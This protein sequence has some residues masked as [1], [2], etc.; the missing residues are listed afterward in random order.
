MPK[1]PEN[2][3]VA[4]LLQEG[5]VAAANALRNLADAPDK[6][7]R[8]AARRGLYLL[9]QKGIAPEERDAS[10]PAAPAP[11]TADTLRAYASACDGAGNRLLFF[12][13]PDPD[14]GRPTLMQT[15]INDEVGVKDFDAVRLARRDM[16]ERLGRFEEQLENGLALAEIEGDYARL[17][18]EE[19]WQITQY[20]GRAT[21]AGFPE[22]RAK[23]GPP[24]QNYEEP[25]VY[26]HLDAE[27]V[28]ADASIPHDPGD[29]FRL[30]W[31]EP[32]FFAVEEAFPYLDQLRELEQNQSQIVVPDSV[33]EE[34]REKHLSE[35]VKGLMDT[36]A[37]DRYVRRLEESAD[38]LRR[39]GKEAEAK[40][41]LYHARM[42]AEAEAVE[43]VPFAR[44]LVT[45]SLGAA[46]EIIREAM[47]RERAAQQGQAT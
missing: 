12:I 8:K 21:P 6:E 17:L 38:I 10:L 14:G 32:W 24:H 9:S 31:F 36:D 41:A 3:Q 16:E 25:I 2:E 46:F 7:T 5:T 20:V 30:S 40:Q 34:R 22:W 18:L 33:K 1:R 44:E 23:V 11:E 35:A 42:L 19:A 13:L 45:R 47:E 39:R 26:V 43:T 4:A 37:R 15:L 28:M 29:L 27:A